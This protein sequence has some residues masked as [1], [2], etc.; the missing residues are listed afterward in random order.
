[1][2]WS[3]MKQGRIKGD[4]IMMNKREFFRRSA[5]LLCLCVAPQ[6]MRDAV[7]AAPAR[8]I[9]LQRSPLAGFQFHRG[10]SFW[11]ALRV[12]APLQLVREPDN[13]YDKRAVRVDWQGAKL[14]YVP[15]H[16]NAAISQLLDRGQSL[17]A[18]IDALRLANDP[19]QRIELV[20][21]LEN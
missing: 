20:V 16:D 4:D 17:V 6:I 18:V 14:G 12:G 2:R 21:Y 9:E 11:S 15:R 13:P 10:E 19:W 1:M 3:L 7:A 5:A 8:R